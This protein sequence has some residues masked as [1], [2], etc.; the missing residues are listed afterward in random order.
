VIRRC[1]AP[2]RQGVL[3]DIIDRGVALA[4]GCWHFEN[5]RARSIV[6]RFRSTADLRVRRTTMRR[7]LDADDAAQFLPPRK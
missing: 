7:Y 4:A 1:I 5:I 3:I 6:D 2:A